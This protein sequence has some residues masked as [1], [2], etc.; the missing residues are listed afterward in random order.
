M[1]SVSIHATH[2]VKPWDVGNN[3]WECQG[4]GSWPERVG[5]SGMQG[6]LSCTGPWVQVD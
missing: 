3:I 6:P 5:A 4:P 1:R 2:P